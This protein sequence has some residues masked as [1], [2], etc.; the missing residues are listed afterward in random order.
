[1]MKGLALRRHCLSVTSNIAAIV[2]MDGRI[3]DDF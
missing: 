1:M 3:L 2:I